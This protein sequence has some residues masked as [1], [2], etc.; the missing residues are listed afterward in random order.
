MLIVAL[1]AASFFLVGYFI[2]YWRNADMDFMVVY[3]VFLMND[4]QPQFYF[5]HPAYFTILLV[6]G[7]FRFLHQFGL[8]DA[9]K[10]SAI[11][12][13]SAAAFDEAMTSAVRAGR[14]LSFWLAIAVVLIFAV[15]MRRIVHDRRLAMIAA[16]AFASSG[17]LAMQMRIMRTE[18][19]AAPLVL[20]AFLILVLA[21]RRATNGRPLVLALAAFL[22]MLGL[23]NKV[24]AI[25]PIAAL[26]LMI[27]PFGSATGTSTSFWKQDPRRWLAAT[28]LAVT[29]LVILWVTLPLIRTGF[30]PIAMAAT[31]PAK[32]LFSGTPGLYQ[33]ALLAWTVVAMV[34]FSTV[35][36]VS[37]AESV[38]GMFAL[39]IGLCAA[40]LVLDISYYD[41]NVVTVMNPLERMLGF[42]DLSPLS[43]GGGGPFAMLGLL[44]LDGGR[45]LLRYTFF[46]S[47]SPRT[48]VFLIWLVVPGIVY[49][50]RRGEK[51]AALQAAVLMLSGFAIDTVGM[52]RGLKDEYF[53]F[54]DPFIIIA[55]A[56]LLDRMNTLRFHRL[57]FPI[58][59]ILI[60]LHVV[61]GQAEPVK[62]GFARRGP[63]G[64]CEWRMQ[65]LPLLQLP[66]CGKA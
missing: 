26:P 8:L 3:N 13:S 28:A 39:V 23:E 34:A 33:A 25:L 56:V 17:A 1:L 54:T 16:F 27:L 11:P 35:W 32:P 45:V 49:A 57:A 48:A 43:G 41:A 38:A 14:L 58:G 19:I 18:L 24:H 62:H 4:G 50:W 61:V 5:D 65:Y 47:S 10:L 36:K 66:W 63:E 6:K 55:G 31:L 53:I 22:C 40:L 12:S 64:I 29:A 7:W 37:F 59:A 20:F 60:T 52:R 42:A 51:Q 46:L 44:A 15:L 30:D 9:W 21:A 2:V